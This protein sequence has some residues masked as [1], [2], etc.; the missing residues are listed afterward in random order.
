MSEY[1]L[2]KDLLKQAYKELDEHVYR[3]MVENE[4]AKA[5]RSKIFLFKKLLREKYGKEEDV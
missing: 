5:C 1:F 3:A 4:E 2:V